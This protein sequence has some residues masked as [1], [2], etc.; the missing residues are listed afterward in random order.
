M[1]IGNPGTGSGSRKAH[2]SDVDIPRALEIEETLQHDLMAEIKVFAAQC[3]RSAGAFIHLGAT[4]M[5]IK[6]NAEVLQIAS[7]S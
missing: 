4:S 7:R 2:A 3:P 5:D 1:G 6:D